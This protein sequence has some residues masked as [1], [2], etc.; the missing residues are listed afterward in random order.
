MQTDAIVDRPELSGVLPACDL[1]VESRA[2]RDSDVRDRLDRSVFAVGVLW[3]AQRLSLGVGELPV[4]WI[5][6]SHS[7]V[8]PIRDSLQMIVDLA[9]IGRID[10]RRAYRE[11]A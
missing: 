9:A 11:G 2:L 6:D 8:H 10:A 3:I 7:K 4:A 1:L 5:D